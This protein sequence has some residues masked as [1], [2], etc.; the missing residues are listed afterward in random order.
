MHGL[1]SVIIRV[2][3][4]MRLL[5]GDSVWSI[6]RVAML[7]LSNWRVVALLTIIL[8]GLI[9]GYGLPIIVNLDRGRVPSQ[10]ILDIAIW[11]VGTFRPL[12][13]L[14]SMLVE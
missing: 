13:P 1:V 10:L 12:C 14:S 4:V 3:H 7:P 11:I 6:W 5:C 8:C 2:L 9:R